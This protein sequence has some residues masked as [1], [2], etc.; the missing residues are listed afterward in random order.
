V[1]GTTNYGTFTFM[2]SGD[3]SAP[4][5]VNYSLGGTAVMW[6]DYYRVEGSDMPVAISIPAGGASYTM[7]IAARANQTGA[8]PE[9]VTLSLSTDPS[10]Q[11]GLPNNAMLTIL[12]GGSTGTTPAPTLRIQKVANGMGL[13]WS[14]VAGKIYRVA[15]KNA[16]AG[17]W[18]DLSGD[19]AAASATTS[20]TDATAANAPQ[21]FYRVYATN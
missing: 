12:P 16:M 11:I 20:W 7:H 17:Q 14:S 9:Y 13:S 21:R 2:R 10:Y 1:I 8:N 18:T 5:T 6:N 3:T 4:L 15:Y 19:I